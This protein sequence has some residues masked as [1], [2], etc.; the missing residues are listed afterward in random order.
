MLLPVRWRVGN[1]PVSFRSSGDSCLS[2]VSVLV[3]SDS[4]VESEAF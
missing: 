3:V 2:F 1:L 4:Q